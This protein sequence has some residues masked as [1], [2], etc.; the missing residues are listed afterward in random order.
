MFKRQLLK[1][2]VTTENM[3]GFSFQGQIWQLGRKMDISLLY[4]GGLSMYW[5]P[6]FCSD[7]IA[8]CFLSPR[9]KRFLP[10]Q[11]NACTSGNGKQTQIQDLLRQMWGAILFLHHP[12]DREGKNSQPLHQLSQ[13]KSSK[14]DWRKQMIPFATEQELQADNGK[15]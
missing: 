11:W 14:V 7:S 9:F 10:S 15:H 5:F 2:F 1:A 8:S 12:W 4:W 6:L 3:T 13:F